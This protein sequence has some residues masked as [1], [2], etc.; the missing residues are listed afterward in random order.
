MDSA[1]SALSLPL[2]SVWLLI[3]ALAA[4]ACGS[5]RSVDEQR[6]DLAANSTGE[7]V[8]AAVWP[9]EAHAD[10]LYREGLELA[11]QEVN[12][13][14]GPRGRPLRL[15]FEDDSGS[16]NQGRLV[17]QRLAGDP[18]IMA[19]I[20]HLQSFVTVPAAAI[21][22]LA[23][24][25]LLAPTATSADL[26]ARSY[27]RV[28]R[29]TFT[30]IAVGRQMADYGLS[31]G[32]E[33]MAIYYIRNDYGRDLANA[34]EE[35]LA[36]LG[37]SVA[38]RDSYDWDDEI[39]PESFQPI[40]DR[41]RQLELDAIFLAGEVPSAG[42]LI[43][44]FRRGGI[45]IP[46]FGSDALFSSALLTAAGEAAD[47][48]V[49]PGIFHPEDPRPEVQAFV[50]RF[51][52]AYGTPPDA[53][54]ALGYDALRLLAHAMDEAPSLTS[55][56]LARTLHALDSWQGV[57]GPVTFDEKGDLKSARLLKVIVRDG[58]FHY[59]PEETASG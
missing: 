25:V 28:F 14:G 56:D 16:V 13:E 12:Q 7:I 6:F 44:E 32:H 27:E 31:R 57:T 52:D 54:S 41:W 37:H 45:D 11:L 24:L 22:D 46:V 9:W 17:A 48:T 19:V 53:G 3:A 55:E 47:G 29:T 10:I 38:A 15:R 21:Y 42:K 5:E 20:G 1:K 43:A 4:F 8:V 51:Q 2:T 34:F 36:G 58:A 40:F 30:D 23:G 33:R 50:R 35:R 39:R 18:E 49:V 26:T 59:L